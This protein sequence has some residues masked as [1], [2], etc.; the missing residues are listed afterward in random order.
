[1]LP[2]HNVFKPSSTNTER[3]L[4]VAVPAEKPTSPVDDATPKIE[5]PAVADKEEQQD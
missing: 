1:M 3:K 2:P 5:E 4:A